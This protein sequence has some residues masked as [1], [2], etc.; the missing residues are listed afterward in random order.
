MGNPPWTISSVRSGSPSPSNNPL[1]VSP[2]YKG[3]AWGHLCLSLLGF[4]RL[5]AGDHSSCEIVIARAMSCFTA[6]P[7]S[8]GSSI[9][10]ASS[11]TMSLTL[12]VVSLILMFHV[13]L[14][15]ES[16]ILRVLYMSPLS[17]ALCRKQ[18][19]C[20]RLRAAQACLCWELDWP[21]SWTDLASGILMQAG[22]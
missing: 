1:P 4:W 20:P 21:G 16:L 7:P 19:L 15:T 22:I 5:D 17:A 9:L 10:P 6:L 13:G 3:R 14:G 2:E 8:S 12:G 11:P 18:P